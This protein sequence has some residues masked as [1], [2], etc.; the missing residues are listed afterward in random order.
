MFTGCNTTN[1]LLVRTARFSALDALGA[2][3]SA[4]HPAPRNS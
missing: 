2:L 1:L 3:V 4:L